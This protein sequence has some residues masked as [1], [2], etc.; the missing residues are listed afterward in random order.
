MA[1]ERIDIVVSERGSKVVKRRLSEI[2]D[3]AERSVRSLRFLQNALFVAGG[4]GA[5]AGLGRLVDT[6]TNFENRLK[7]VTD[8]SQAFNAV[9]TEVFNV[10]ARTRAEFE[11]TATIFSRTALAVRELGISQQETLNFTESLNQ[12]TIL[13]GASVRES[14]AA[15]IQLSQG[16]ASSTLRGDELRSVMEQLPFVADVIAKEL[17]VTRGELRLLGQD[18]K[19]SAEIVLQA[20]RNAREEIAEKF[21]QTIPTIG[22][23][24]SVLRTEFIRIV[25]KVDDF[26]SGSSLLAQAIIGLSQSLDLLIA[27]ILSAGAA[28]TAFKITNLIKAQ[29][30]FSQ[31]IASGNATLLTSVEIERAKAV[32]SLQSAQATS[33]DTAAT[34]RAAQ[35]DIVR[36]QQQRSLAAIQANSIIID[37][38]RRVARDALTGRFIAYDLAVQQ[39]IR[40]NILLAR[41]DKLL[42]ASRV[43]LARATAAQTQAEAALTAAQSR[44]AVAGA[45]ANTFTARLARTFPGLAGIV[46]IVARAFSG[47]WLIVAANPL[48]AIVAAIAAVGITLGFL[49]DK[50]KVTS[51][52]VVTLRDVFVA[53]FQIMSEATSGLFDS[54]VN[55]FEPISDVLVD[56]FETVNTGVEAALSSYLESHKNFAN[57]VIGIYI[58]VF[59]SIRALFNNF[60]PIVK[61]II[62]I[63]IESIF[64]TVE[65]EIEAFVRQIGDLLETIGSVKEKFGLENPFANLFDDF[66]ISLGSNRDFAKG[67]AS[68]FAAIVQEEF[69]EAFSTDYLGDLWDSV[70]NRARQIATER[71]TLDTPSS[72]TSNN[73]AELEELT[74]DFEKLRQN[75]DGVYAAQQKFA[76]GEKLVNSALKAGLVTQEQ[77]IRLTELL[78]RERRASILTAQDSLDPFSAVIR[79]LNEETASLKLNGRER[80]INNRLVQIQNDLKSKGIELLP[81]QRAQLEEAVRLNNRLADPGPWQEM[82]NGLQDVGDEIESSLVRGFESAAD[83]I[84][85]MVVDGKFNLESLGDV[86]NGIAKELISL[87]IRQTAIGIGSSI[88]GFAKGGAFNGSV[89]PFAS[90]GVLNS[91]IAFPMSTGIGV[92]GEAGPEAIMPLTKDSSGVLGVRSSGGGGGTVI[93]ANI[94]VDASGREN[95]AEVAEETA[96]AFENKILRRVP[97]IAIS[98]VDSDMSKGGRLSRTVRKV[99]N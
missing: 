42:A 25:D 48:A 36:I 22:Q 83:A 96:R 40:N 51:D 79:D 47:L 37:N 44:S 61:N 62:E 65:L 69:G 84:A 23:S 33:V 81:A 60:G 54:I 8:T 95:P 9:Q 35:A 28:F 39:N 66:D 6:V 82:I 29:R 50:I 49:S 38:R 72:T 89:T 88:F 91:P 16:L 10:A 70:L 98:A 7:L 90:G 59:N 63:A 74:S 41:T 4:A 93:N 45:A 17:G 87:G 92:A 78:N 57:A 58:A 18:G 21:A 27:G 80:E 13:S 11:S 85:D 73:Q 52:G 55:V 5:L 46:G 1:T 56:V 14:N 30:E 34:L 77:A 20:F 19:I 12:A 43:D 53:A 2:G 26:T 64:N 97:G 94:T 67:P 3:T 99:A 15:L 32:S 24:I 68:E 71:G 86:I 75:L 76:E 31:A